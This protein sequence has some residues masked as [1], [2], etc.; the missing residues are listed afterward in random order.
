MTLVISVSD[1][2][3]ARYW[4]LRDVESGLAASIRPSDAGGVLLNGRGNWYKTHSVESAP[5]WDTTPG[6]VTKT[7]NTDLLCVSISLT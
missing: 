3:A 1:E 5:R 7:G 6:G 2:G 4:G